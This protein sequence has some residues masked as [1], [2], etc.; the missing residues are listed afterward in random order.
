MKC[1]K[2]G[3]ENLEPHANFPAVRV[4]I[5]KNSGLPHNC[6]SIVIKDGKWK[7][8]SYKMAANLWASQR[9]RDKKRLDE[10]KEKSKPNDNGD[11]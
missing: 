2:C 8:Y 3:T 4:L 1:Y 6:E 10:I 7:G 5:D 9:A 11:Q